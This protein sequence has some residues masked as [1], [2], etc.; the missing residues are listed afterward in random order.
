[1][2]QDRYLL[3]AS[4]GQPKHIRK[5]NVLVTNQI[6][7]IRLDTIKPDY[8][9]VPANKDLGTPPSPPVPTSHAVDHF[10]CY[11]VKVTPGTSA[12]RKGVQVNVADQFTS[13]GPAKIMD[14]KKPKHLCLAVDKNG[15]GVKNPT[16][17]LLCYLAKPA[18]GQPKHVPRFPVYT[19]DQF[20]S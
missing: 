1:I 8:L 15:E 16:A 4:T 6:G 13:P 14:L 18:K 12:F 3:R 9:M 17:N 20:G 19:A 2:H 11:K 5:T 7:V 10:K